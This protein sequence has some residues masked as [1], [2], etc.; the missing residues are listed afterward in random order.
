MGPLVFKTSGAA[1]GAARWVRLPCAPARRIDADGS[2]T[3]DPPSVETVLAAARTR[4][5]PDADPR[6]ARGCGARSVV[7]E[8]RAAI[9]AGRPAA[10][11][12]ALADERRGAPRRPGG[13]G[14]TGTIN[15]TGVILHTNLGRAPWPAVAIEAAAAA[16]GGYLLLELDRDDRS[17]RRR[18]SGPP[19]NT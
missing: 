2:P 11:L 13:A 18:G 5:G 8:E 4:L 12:D 19:R 9:A 6:G 3:A 15:A 7:D 1:L 10:P 14:P 16:A 17:A